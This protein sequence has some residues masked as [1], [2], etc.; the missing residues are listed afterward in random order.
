MP[1]PALV[2]DAR[3][4]IES[5]TLLLFVTCALLPV[6]AFALLGYMLVN[7]QLRQ[8][9]QD[10]LDAA[11]K[12]YGLLIYDR[13]QKVDQ[14]LAVLAQRYLE[15]ELST[16][17]IESFTDDR[18]H[19]SVI[20]VTTPVAT[21]IDSQ[22]PS[23]SHRLA[24]PSAN[25]R[26]DVVI[27]VTARNNRAAIKLAAV[28]TPEYLW[29]SDALPTSDTTLCVTDADAAV[30]NCVAND[31][32]VAK[33]LPIGTSAPAPQMNSTWPLFLNATYGTPDWTVRI[34]LP[35]SA[36]LSA[37]ASFRWL[38]PL[39]AA[40]SVAIAL[41]VGSVFIRRSHAPLR[42]LTDA[43]RRIGRRRF[44]RPIRIDSNDEYGR[45]ARSFNRMASSLR[46]QFDLLA[47]LARV[48]RTILSRAGTQPA[49]SYLL[50]RLP[51][52][53]K[54]PVAG[55]LLLKDDADFELNLV[56]AESGRIQTS[57]LRSQDLDLSQLQIPGP[58]RRTGVDA[59]TA[60]LVSAFANVGSDQIALEPVIVKQCVRGYVIVG[61]RHVH[62]QSSA[63]KLR[64][65]AHRLAV[66]IGND[67]RERALWQQAHT[68]SLTGLPNRLLLRQRL[69][70][71]LQPGHQ[72]QGSQGAVIFMDLDRFK[73]V[74]D[75]LGHTLGD[76]LLQQVATRLTTALTA[77][78]TL[79]R[80]GGDEFVVMLPDATRAEAGGLTQQLLDSL[81]EP[82]QLQETRYVAQ[83][84]AGIAM[85]PDDG[86]DVDTVLKNAD[87]A[88]Y[89][90]K[91]GG[92]GRLCFFDNVM[93]SDVDERLA[94]EDRLREAI[95][96]QHICA[97]FQPKLDGAGD[98]VGVEALARWHPADQDPVSPS[99]FI[100]L[101]EETGLIVPLGELIL[102]ESCRQH[103]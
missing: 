51:R 21:T 52:L 35:E 103:A 53:L 5:R 6:V 90:A 11:A 44:N 98:V 59:D 8:L 26:R 96:E 67:D 18:A 29:N 92:R 99:V 72:T 84:S 15:G 42:V 2:R 16:R 71:A 41:L 23:I 70:A 48:D 12:N 37:L 17:T 97:W 68:D 88:L 22:E 83:A 63:N 76:S 102:R 82:L 10:R 58:H 79:A 93:S 46:D 100:P 62:R 39:T 73:S 66:A 40:L 78:A 19:I 13:M 43:A 34:G 101:A 89:R 61:E 64:D 50:Q 36:A 87:I 25:G 14:H 85:F 80:F 38:L 74:N 54:C 95:R 57:A 20:E 4:R 55:I 30:L 9:A 3:T 56:V 45:L 91:A 27:E 28:L 7:A 94:L 47:V 1:A 81:S 60:P 65:I 86:T 31:A 24:V 32:P 69:E 75:S 33:T 49:V 77:T